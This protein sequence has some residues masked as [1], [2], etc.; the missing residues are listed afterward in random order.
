M[1]E[2]VVAALFEPLGLGELKVEERCHQCLPQLIWVATECTIQE[3]K[4]Q[5]VHQSGSR[6]LKL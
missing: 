5:P 2:V 6:H 3:V 4:E 1:M